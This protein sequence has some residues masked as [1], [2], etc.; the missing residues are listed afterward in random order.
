MSCLVLLTQLLCR[1][2]GLLPQPSSW[3]SSLEKREEVVT[4]LPWSWAIKHVTGLVPAGIYGSLAAAAGPSCQWPRGPAERAVDEQGW[5]K[6]WTWPSLPSIYAWLSREY[7]SCSASSLPLENLQA[8]EDVSES[9]SAVKHDTVTGSNCT[10]PKSLGLHV[11]HCGMKMLV[12]TAFLSRNKDMLMYS[13]SNTMALNAFSYV[14][15]NVL[16]F[17]GVKIL[18]CLHAPSLVYILQL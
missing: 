6:L 17:E 11:Q 4:V 12:H 13:T 7:G 2:P 5:S 1:G 14:V 9:G 16:T 8:P 3:Q 18:I 10:S 15:L